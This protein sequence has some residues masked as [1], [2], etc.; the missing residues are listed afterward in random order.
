MEERGEGREQDVQS[1]FLSED[2]RV[3]GRFKNSLHFDH[4]MSCT[5]FLRTRCVVIY[6]LLKNLLNTFQPL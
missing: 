1:V 6:L 5:L 2:E 4:V 3:I